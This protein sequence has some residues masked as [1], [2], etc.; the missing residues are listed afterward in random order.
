MSGVDIEDDDRKWRRGRIG[1]EGRLPN[2]TGGEVGGAVNWRHG[3]AC[4]S[5]HLGAKTEEDHK[6]EAALSTQQDSASK[7]KPKNR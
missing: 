4:I 2:V 6:L 1:E 7:T 3:D 5:Q